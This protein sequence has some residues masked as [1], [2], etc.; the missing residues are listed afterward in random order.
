LAIFSGESASPPLSGV[1]FVSEDK[2]DNESTA[3][4]NDGGGDADNE[5]D[6]EIDDIAAVGDVFC[7]FLFAEEEEEV[8]K[9]E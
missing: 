1:S 3:G 5:S 9:E 7:F 4:D 8:E 6:D 2:C